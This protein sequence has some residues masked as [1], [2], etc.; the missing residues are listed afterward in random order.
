[1]AGNVFKTRVYPIPKFG[2]RTLRV[3]TACDLKKGVYA[4]PIKIDDQLVG[5]CVVT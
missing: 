1:M 2:V 5:E 3:L 4:L